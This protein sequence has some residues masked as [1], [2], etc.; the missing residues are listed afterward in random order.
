MAKQ[1]PML[2]G[3]APGRVDSASALGMLNE[4]ANTPI[5]PSAFGLAQGFADMYRAALCRDRRYFSVGDTIAVNM[6]DN[7]LVGV[8][9]NPQ[10]GSI[11]IS[12]SGIPHPDDVDVTVQSAAPISKVQQKME[13][14]NEFKNTRI[15]AT[16][17]RIKAR[18]LNLDLPVGNDIEWENFVTARVE[19][20]LLFHDGKSVPEGEADK[21]GVLFSDKAD[22]HEIHVR[23]HREL[24]ASIKFKLA[25]VTVR[26]RIQ[27]HIDLH[28]AAM[29]RIPDQMPMLEDAAEQTLM[30]PGSMT[31]G[32]LAPGV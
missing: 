2:S 29:G 27:K 22:M 32:N 26:D 18:L 31:L 8:V 5:A 16:E 9:Y 28:E 3:E 10:N 17:Y 23:V 15:D 4:S 19:N 12:D 21:V 20:V 24:V 13:L 11:K 1:P 6:L 14:E 25:D 7:A 30:Q